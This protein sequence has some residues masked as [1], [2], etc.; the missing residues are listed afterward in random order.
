M[1]NLYPTLLLKSVFRY[2]NLLTG[3]L[4][5]LHAESCE[6]HIVILN[7]CTFYFK[8]VFIIRQQRICLKC[9]RPQFYPWVG[10]IPWRRK[11]QPT[12]VFLPGEF[13]GQR[14]LVGHS[15]WGRQESDTLSDLHFIIKPARSSNTVSKRRNDNGLPCL[16]PNLDGMVFK[17]GRGEGRVR[18]MGS[19]METYISVCKIDNQRGFAVFLRKLK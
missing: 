15:P 16:I 14:G 5:Y 2:S 1:L 9:R 13:H 12:L 11:W 7:P 19:N 17:L 4:D 10:R 3:C 6:W 8:I 18:C